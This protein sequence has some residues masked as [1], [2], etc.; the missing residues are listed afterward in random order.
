MKLK[1]NIKYIASPSKIIVTFLVLLFAIHFLQFIIHGIAMTFELRSIE[2]RDKAEQKLRQQSAG[3]DKLYQLIRK[4]KFKFLPD[5]KIH[6]ISGRKDRYNYRRNEIKP[7]AAIKIYD[8]KGD[9][10][11]EGLAKDKPYQY[12]AWAE[13]P[14][15][16]FDDRRMKEMQMIIP[17]MSRSLEIPVRTEDQTKEFWQY[18]SVRD[19]FTGYDIN[20]RKIGC[21]DANGFSQNTSQLSPFGKS[22]NCIAWC[23]FDSYSP[24]L[25]WQSEKKIYQIDFEKRQVTTLF[26][27][28]DSAIDSVLERYWMLS[29]VSEKDK[30]GYRPLIQCKT[31]DG[32]YHL[33]MRDP[34]QQF[35]I[36][37][38][39]D[40][41]YS[42]TATDKGIFAYYQ[43]SDPRIP[44]SYLGSPELVNKWIQQM[45]GKPINHWI[46]F[47]KVT[48]TGEFEQVNRMDWTKKIR[49]R[50][51]S[52]REI[53]FSQNVLEYLSSFSP[54]VYDSIWHIFGSEF[55]NRASR[56][57]GLMDAVSEVVKVLRPA[58]NAICWTLSVVM[59]ALVV[60]HGRA[61]RTSWGRLVF[62]I[63]F[64]GVFNLT[65]L[66]TYLALN[67][68]VVIK[69]SV[70]GQIRGLERVDCIHCRG[71]LPLPIRKDTDL[72]LSTQ[73][74]KI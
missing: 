9:M 12:L 22:K 48:D 65:G 52:S 34:E 4:S 16:S 68:T 30:I 62:W 11:W 57:E 54:A 63:V 39:D 8:V 51:L 33:I 1:E 36:K 20:G 71:E 58:K 60:L 44:K 50:S 15:G 7:D 67:H 49:V 41:R 66:L 23:P 64:A 69:C 28:T 29:K 53:S 21:I 46:E 56:S 2:S 25:L 70:C 38:P 14:R 37:V 19:I 5:G 40:R 59:M 18:D 42:F 17:E 32:M 35:S 55:W 13:Y 74:D 31:D 73:P 47:V 45:E 6:L 43:Y 24:K 26:K 27:T 61:R 72:I 3:E 10:I